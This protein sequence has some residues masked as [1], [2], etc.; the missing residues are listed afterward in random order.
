MK[1]IILIFSIAG[2]LAGFSVVSVLAD[3]T[4]ATS[5]SLASQLMAQ[6]ENL[7]AQ[8]EALKTQMT[9]VKTTQTQITQT[10]KLIKL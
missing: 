9:A 7:R 6:I 8:I 1:K 4:G 5:D 2:V 10:L 3:T